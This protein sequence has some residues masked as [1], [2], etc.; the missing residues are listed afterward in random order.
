[1]EIIYRLD[2]TAFTWGEGALEMC[3][4]ATQLQKKAKAIPV[5]GLGGL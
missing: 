2:N 3:L 4:A 1:M 5:T